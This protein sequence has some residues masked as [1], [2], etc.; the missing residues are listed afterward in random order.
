MAGAEVDARSTSS[1]SPFFS[2]VEREEGE[3]GRGGG[4]RN[5]SNVEVVVVFAVALLCG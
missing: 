3:G 2:G 5:Q 1:D 4:I